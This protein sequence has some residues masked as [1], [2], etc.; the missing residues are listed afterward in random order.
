MGKGL[1]MRFGYIRP[2]IVVICMWKDV[3]LVGYIK[4]SGKRV[5]NRNILTYVGQIVLS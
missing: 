4:R 2:D 5:Y 1:N 3:G